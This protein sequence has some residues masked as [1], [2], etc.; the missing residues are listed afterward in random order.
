SSQFRVLD[1][2]MRRPLQNRV[3]PWGDLVAD[4]VRYQVPTAVFGN[5]GCLH[6]Q[7]KQVVRNFK[8]ESWLACELV[9]SRNRPV[10]RDD[11]RA[12]NGRKRVVMTP[13]HYTELFFLDGYVALA[14]GH[15]PCACCKRKEFNAF[16]ALWARVH[17]SRERW[18]AAA[19]DKQLHSE[20]LS[21]DRSKHTFRAA[22]SELPDGTFVT[23]SGDEKDAWLLWKGT[24]HLWS[25][26]GYHKHQSVTRAA[27]SDVSVLTPRS[28]VDVLKAGYDAGMPHHS[29]CYDFPEINS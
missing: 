19:I 5:R 26:N 3:T 20:R 29:V 23:L 2:N 18:R 22:L 25:H 28:L 17:P 21:E 1:L 15:R 13:G 14:S 8:S 6:N 24:L 11:N 12:F 7:D 4:P 16:M 10:Q 9:V 27:D